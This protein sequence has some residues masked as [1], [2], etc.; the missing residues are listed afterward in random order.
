MN[1][2]KLL[3]WKTLFIYL[4]RWM[5]I[6]FGLVF[7]VWFVSGVAMMY[8]SMPHLSAKERLGHLQPLNLST[9]RVS[10]AEAVRVNDLEPGRPR[11]E[12][13]YDGRP[14]YRFDRGTKVYAD[15]GGLV[16]G[17]SAEQAVRLIRHG[18][19]NTPRRCGTTR[20]S[21]IPISGRST[22]SSGRRCRC[23]G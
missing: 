5:G 19:R 9:A 21:S 1:T 3:D 23:T 7:V 13:Y 4:H 10:M 8:V 12:M 2:R 16:G 14:I 6:V 11:I 18:Y 22:T 20:I 17:A 15:T